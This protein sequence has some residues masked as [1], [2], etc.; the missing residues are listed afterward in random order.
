VRKF[1]QTV[2]SGRD[3]PLWHRVKTIEV[4]EAYNGVLKPSEYHMKKE[5][6]DPVHVEANKNAESGLG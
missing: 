3:M 4:C 6:E 5:L 1:V 2:Y